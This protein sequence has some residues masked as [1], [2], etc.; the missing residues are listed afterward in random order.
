MTISS[1]QVWQDGIETYRIRI[2]D[3][4]NMAIGSDQFRLHG[5]KGLMPLNVDYRAVVP[6]S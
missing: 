5:I 6:R 2:P 4:D 1:H 3:V